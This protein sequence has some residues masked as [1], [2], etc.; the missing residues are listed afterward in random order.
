[1]AAPGK[2][3]GG[4]GA[5]CKLPEITE[6]NKAP[7]VTCA[8]YVTGQ[9]CS[10]YE[11]RPGACRAFECGYMQNPELGEEWRPDKAGFM[12]YFA[13]GPRLVVE[14]DLTT[15]DTWKAEPFI[16]QLRDWSRRDRPTVFE[17]VVRTGRH[18]TMVFPEGEIV[19]GEDQNQPIRSGYRD[20]GG[21]RV[22]FAEFAKPSAWTF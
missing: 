5:C 11:L 17:V 14:T 22:P 6:L 12:L 10:I 13:P 19:L 21:R 7:H 20:V 4:C 8:N 2:S 3:C 15:P 16:S 18:L 9:G 1:M